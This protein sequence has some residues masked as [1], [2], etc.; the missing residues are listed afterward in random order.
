MQEDRLALRALVLCAAGRDEV[1][2]AA[3]E[4]FRKSY[5]R[6]LYAKRVDEACP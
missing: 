1:G 2:A 6:S 5:A 3:A 4:T